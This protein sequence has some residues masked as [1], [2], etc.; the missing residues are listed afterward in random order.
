MGKAGVNGEERAL[1]LGF[2]KFLLRS[3]N[4]ACSVVGVPLRLEYPLDS[5][6]SKRSRVS[7]FTFLG[8][9]NPVRFLPFRG[10]RDSQRV[11]ANSN[12]LSWSWKKELGD[13]RCVKRLSSSSSLLCSCSESRFASRCSQIISRGELRGRNCYPTFISS[14]SSSS[15]SL[16]HLVPP[17]SRGPGC[18]SSRF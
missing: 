11:L 2:F 9:I 12:S 3:R 16:F 8:T 14:S 5:R 4:V 17:F 1:K 10:T 7:R 13:Y 6:N 18:P 15:S